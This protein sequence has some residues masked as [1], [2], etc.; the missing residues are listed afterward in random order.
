MK[1]VQSSAGGEINGSRSATDAQGGEAPLKVTLTGSPDLDCA[2]LVLGGGPGGY[3][4]AF[5][6]ADLG[7][8]TVLVERYP[9]LGGVCLN[10][11]CIPSK[12]LLHVAALVNEASALGERG[13]EFGPPTVD[14]ERLRAWKND[15]VDRLTQGLGGM[16]KGRDVEVLRGVGQLLDPHHLEVQMTSGEGRDVTGEKQIVRFER[17][18]IAAGSRVRKLPFM[19]EDPRVV[20][21]A[22]ALELTEIP[23]RML[24]LGGGIIGLE[25][26]TVYSTLGARIDLVEVLDDLMAGPDRDL[27]AVWRKWNAHRFDR[28][29][30]GTKAVAVDAKKDGL[31]VSFEGERAPEAAQQYDLIL[32]A[33]G[34]NPN[35][36]Q[37]GAERA[38][39]RVSPDGFIPVDK[40]MR[41]NIDHIFAIGDIAGGP[42]LAH[43]AVHEGHVAAEAAAGRKSYFDAYAIPNVAYTD[44]EV[45]WVG[46]TEAG[47]RE[48]D[49]EVGVSKFPWTASGR[50]L[51]NG[52]AEGFTK[53]V[54]DPQSHRILGGAIVGVN[55]GD[56]IGEVVLAIEMGAD[57]TD[58]GHTIHA[59]PTLSESIGLAAEVYEGICTDLPRVRKG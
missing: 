37:I 56:L 49:R 9:K 22:G 36:D 44:P 12:A 57:A 53:L 32:E 17:L 15:V 54:F 28:I 21:S 47:A 14:L 38:G 8:Q 6:S 59:H 40:Q 30:E 42:M 20:D 46:L 7:A 39:I 43:K 48:E 23:E 45:A 27:V 29:M 2:T 41:T 58:M 5:R 13:V 35:G 11:G 1:Q 25:L 4:A 55:A 16:A 50:A 18:I 33:V 24:V 26:A 51:A 3:S 10:V 19:P 52:R 31:W 34:R